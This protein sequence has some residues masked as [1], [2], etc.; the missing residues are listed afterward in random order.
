MSIETARDDQPAGAFTA[1]HAHR[2]WPPRKD[3]KARERAQSRVRRQEPASTFSVYGTT[4]TASTYTS[5]HARFTQGPN[6]HQPHSSW[7][8]AVARVRRGGIVSFRNGLKVLPI[9]VSLFPFQRTKSFTPVAAFPFRGS[10]S[11]RS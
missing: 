5:V 10:I 6:Q 1:T 2:S 7:L 9:L 11:S 8:A 4:S 3:A